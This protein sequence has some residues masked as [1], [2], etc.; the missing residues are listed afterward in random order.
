MMNPETWLPIQ[1]RYRSLYAS[2][3]TG[4]AI[5]VTLLMLSAYQPATI[6]KTTSELFNPL[7]EYLRSSNE[8]PSPMESDERMLHIV[9][10]SILMALV[11]SSSVA[12]V[13]LNLHNAHRLASELRSSETKI[14][15]CIKSLVKNQWETRQ[16]IMNAR[17]MQ[18]GHLRP[19]INLQDMLDF[20]FSKLDKN[21]AKIKTSV[22]IVAD[23]VGSMNQ[24]N[25]AYH[26][27]T[28]PAF[29]L[30]PQSERA[31]TLG[32]MSDGSCN[33]SLAPVSHNKP[34]AWAANS[35]CL[36]F[37]NNNNEYGEV[38]VDGFSQGFDPN[39]GLRNCFTPQNTE[40]SMPSRTHQQT[41][42]KEKPATF[43]KRSMTFR[44]KQKSDCF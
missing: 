15:D 44:L 30:P 24:N 28:G 14:Y 4:S 31:A 37:Q 26:Q 11:V 39:T 9:S 42:S 12:L 6:E 27:M 8:S 23:Q 22:E 43:E 40:V 7:L 38:A 10:V 18:C 25:P 3:M 17:C 35:P 1:Y 34:D 21:I 2:A 36:N 29:V 5:L 20:K 13:L 33:P 41:V 19:T 16:L 32:Y